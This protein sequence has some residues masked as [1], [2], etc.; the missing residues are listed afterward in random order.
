MLCWTYFRFLS[1]QHNKLAICSLRG[2][3]VANSFPRL[4]YSFVFLM[5]RQ[6]Y[7]SYDLSSTYRRSMANK[8]NMLN[9]SIVFGKTTSTSFAYKRC[10]QHCANNISFGLN[11]APLALHCLCILL[12]LLIQNSPINQAALTGTEIRKMQ[13]KCQIK[14][15]NNARR[16][17]QSPTPNVC[18]YFRPALVFARH[19]L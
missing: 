14:W 16:H 7:W 6:Y 12:H 4:A 3:V 8:K 11:M 5:M 17:S 1:V 13:N 2:E 18:L 19:Y 10:V 9:I 15:Q